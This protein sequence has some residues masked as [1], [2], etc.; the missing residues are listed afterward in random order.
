M[1]RTIILT[2]KFSLI[3]KI[4]VAARTGGIKKR[5][6]ILA[7]GRSLSVPIPAIKIR[8]DRESRIANNSGEPKQIREDKIPIAPI[9]TS[10]LPNIVVPKGL[11]TKGSFSNGF[12]ED[13][14]LY[15]PT[16][17]KMSPNRP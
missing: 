6:A 1:I 2:K 7:Q 3:I 14:I 12:D 11:P 9:I 13:D 8:I 17:K 16:K 5:F 15:I 4:N 10:I